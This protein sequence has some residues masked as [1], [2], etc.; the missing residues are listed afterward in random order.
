[1]KKKLFQA[2]SVM[3]A[4]ILLCAESI[5]VVSALS[6]NGTASS[7]GDGSSTTASTGGY[8]IPSMLTVNSNR[9]VGYRFTIIDAAGTA[10]KSCQDVFRYASYSS[11]GPDFLGYYK[12]NTKYPKTY[13]KDNYTSGSY[14]TSSRTTNC[15]YDNTLGL[16]LPEATTGLSAWCTNANIGI[17]LSKLWSITISTLESNSWAILIEPI[18]PLKIQGTYHSLTV[19]E[20]GVYG[21]AKF[22]SGNNGGASANSNSWGFISEY[23]NRHM[24]NSLRLTSTYAGMS[25]ASESSA[26]LTFANIITKGYGAAIVYGDYL[27]QPPEIVDWTYYQSSYNGFTAYIKTNKATSLQVKAWTD[28]NG[29]DDAKTYTATSQNNTISGI[30][31]NWVIYIPKS[32]HK[33]EIGLYWLNYYAYS[34]SGRKAEEYGA[35]QPPNITSTTVFEEESLGFYEFANAESTTDMKIAVYTEPNGNDDLVWYEA[36]LEPNT[37]YGTEYEWISYVPFSKHDYSMDTYIIDFYVKNE[38]SEYLLS[39]STVFTP[40]VSAQLIVEYCEVWKNELSD[41]SELLGITYGE[42]I[43]D[44]SPNLKY[45]EIGDNTWV[46]IFFR[47]ENEDVPIR[48]SVW[49]EGSDQIYTRDGFSIQDAWFDVD[50]TPNKIDADTEFFYICARADLLNDKGEILVKG[51]TKRFCIPVQPTS[52]GYGVTAYSI[53]GDI[54]ASSNIKGNCGAVYTGQRIYPEYEFR[55]ENSWNTYT[56]IFAEIFEWYGDEW[57]NATLLYCD[58]YYDLC[59]ESLNLYNDVNYIAPSM[60]C[61]YIVPDNSASGNNEIK[62]DLSTCWSFWMDDTWVINS[63]TIPIVK[64]DLELSAIKLVDNEGYIIDHNNLIPGQTL[65]VRY[66]YKNNTA[67]EV[68]INGYDDNENL[69]D[70][71]YS[72]PANSSISVDGGKIIVPDKNEFSIWGG[73]FLEGSAIH[74]TDYESNHNN[75]ELYLTCKTA[76]PLEIKAIATNAPYRLNTNVITSYW[77]LNGSSSDITPET[78]ISICFE[79]Y[80]GNGKL[81]TEL[82]KNNIVVPANDKNLVFFKWHIPDKVNGNILKTKSFII[83]NEVQS[84]TNSYTPIDYTVYSTPDTKYEDSSPVGFSVPL[85]P[86]TQSGYATWWQYEYINNEFVKKN[87][88][89]G[90]NSD[91]TISLI[92]QSP[93]TQNNNLVTKSGYPISVEFN[94]SL[95]KVSGYS[96][97]DS[98]AYTDTQYIIAKFPEFGYSIGIDKCRTLI[99]DEVWKFRKNATYGNVHFIPIYYPNTDYF[100]SFTKSDLWTPAGMITSI[101]TSQQLTI[102]GSAF[103][104]WYVGR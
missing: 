37:V 10:K 41:R 77:I 16:S 15:Y 12:F 92:S 62:F 90:L 27:E 33:N 28:N 9:A 52:Y 51:K 66:Y 24:P 72:I 54:S 38:H 88:G 64:S 26:K 7:S 82:Y 81:I 5:S 96:L 50:V 59:Y 49:L 79:V 4:V 61:P 47:P 97:P 86:S 44:Y 68:Y 84:A 78:G 95:S 20:I 29:D 6:F 45:P 91:E 57:F 65:N 99:Y 34:A 46:S 71:I 94:N 18:F 85:K 73:I 25:S 39:Y 89:I 1:M 76:A 2:V 98:K 3:L 36:Q 80:D 43:N 101:V 103:D 31:Y 30:T 21:T 87:Y 40:N 53:T 74:N 19:T 11:F 22:G 42:N 13:Y 93:S 14:S 100:V 35:Y 70:G 56:N 63:F 69:L 8:A 23:T 17:I 67:C 32:N 60:L 48:Q 58:E 83:G 104:D 75:N 102:E 55:S